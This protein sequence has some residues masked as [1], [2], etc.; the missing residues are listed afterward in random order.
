MP[1]V[2]NYLMTKSTQFFF[3]VFPYVTLEK[4]LQMFYWPENYGLEWMNPPGNLFQQS[5][6]IWAY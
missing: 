3:L 1:H 2:K 6:K 5:I 4:C